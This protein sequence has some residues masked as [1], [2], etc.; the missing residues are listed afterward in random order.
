VDQHRTDVPLI[1]SLQPPGWL[2]QVPDGLQLCVRLTPKAS[3]DGVDGVEQTADGQV[4]LKARV[5]AVPE[6]GKANRA[7]IAL[8]A[9]RS[10]IAKSR[11]RLISGEASRLKTLMIDGD[12]RALLE[13]VASLAD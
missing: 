1:E 12:N 3:R 11:F 13:I 2:R 7:L 4:Y 9:K 10:G 5:R 6:K 8:L